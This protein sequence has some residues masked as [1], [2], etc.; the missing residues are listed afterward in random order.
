MLTLNGWASTI[1]EAVMPCT[2]VS[3]HLILFVS[4]DRQF[5]LKLCDRLVKME[6]T[7]E[8]VLEEEL[9]PVKTAPKKARME[10]AR[11]RA[12][13]LFCSCKICMTVNGSS[14]IGSPNP[15]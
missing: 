3:S 2:G 11:G 9:T 12:K 13:A 1:Y 4:D 15:I 8:N 6:C 5:L 10:A 7:R 14:R